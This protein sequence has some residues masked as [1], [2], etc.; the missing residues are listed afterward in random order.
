M[1]RVAYELG[2]TYASATG[3]TLFLLM[4]PQKFTELKNKLESVLWSSDKRTG[5]IV[6]SPGDSRFSMLYL[7]EENEKAGNALI[8]KLNLL[9]PSGEFPVKLEN[10]SPSFLG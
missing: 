5:V 6:L 2:Q 1:G 4:K 8:E 3:W 9:L 7:V 10:N